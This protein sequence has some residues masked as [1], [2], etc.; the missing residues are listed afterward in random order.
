MPS[1][2]AAGEGGHDGD[3]AGHGHG[4]LHD[5]R[6]DDVVL[7]LLVDDVVDERDD[8]LRRLVE[9]APRCRRRAAPR[10]APT[11]GISPRKPTATASTAAYGM[12]T[13]VIMIQPQMRVDGRDRDLADGVAADPPHDLLGRAR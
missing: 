1:S 8:R 9:D 7:D 4:P 11:I 2:V 5:P 12:P 10:V 3:R 13:I 6:H